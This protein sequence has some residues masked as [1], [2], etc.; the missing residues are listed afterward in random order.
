MRKKIIMSLM[1]NT[2]KCNAAR[3]VSMTL[4]TVSGLRLAHVTRV[5][6]MYA[7]PLREGPSLPWPPQ[8]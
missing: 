7:V 6:Y 3:L 2:P 5:S 1:P 4:I 8:G